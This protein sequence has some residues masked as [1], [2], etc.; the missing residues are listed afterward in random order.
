MI[1][2][3]IAHQLVLGATNDE[4]F[5]ADLVENVMLPMLKEIAARHQG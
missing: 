1:G 2:Q 4:A 5:A 3:A